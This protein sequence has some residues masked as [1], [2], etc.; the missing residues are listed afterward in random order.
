MA[1]VLCVLVLL[2]VFQVSVT[3]GLDTDT[4]I[5]TLADGQR[6][7]IITLLRQKSKTH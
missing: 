7:N 5:C 4:Y 2:E 1:L 6:V 3:Y